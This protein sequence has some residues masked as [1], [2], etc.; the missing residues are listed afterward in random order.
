VDDNDDVR[1]ADDKVRERV[2]EK[3]SVD[4]HEFEND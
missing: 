4:V 1:V 2:D 3:K